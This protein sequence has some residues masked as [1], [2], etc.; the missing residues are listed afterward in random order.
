VDFVDS[1]GVTYD[2][3][4]AGLKSKH[5]DLKEVT[6]QITSHLRK[7]DRLA[8]DVR[9]LTGSQAAGVRNF[10]KSLT[11]EQSSRVRILE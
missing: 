9:G 8:V 4:A 6:D 3:V 2:L 7:A 1:K 5:F 10:V 11:R